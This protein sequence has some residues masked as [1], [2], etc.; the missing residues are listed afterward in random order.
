MT[1]E[2][3]VS[4]SQA[5]PHR[6]RRAMN[7]RQKRPR[8]RLRAASPQS[9]NDLAARPVGYITPLLLSEA[10]VK[11]FGQRIGRRSEVCREG[12]V[13]IVWSA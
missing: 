1:P 2:T 8:V 12:L 5:M 13:T 11:G 6:H 3:S 4:T 7:R 10:L 9:T